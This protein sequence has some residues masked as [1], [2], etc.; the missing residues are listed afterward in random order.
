MSLP[1][2]RS[3]GNLTADRRYDYAAALLKDGDAAAA[4]ELLEQALE[5]EPAWTVGWF[6]LGGARLEAG[7]QSGAIAALREV[8][9]LDPHDSLGAGLHLARLGAAGTPRETA[10]AYVRDLF[11]DY[12]SRFDQALVVGLGYQAP[13]LIAAALRT[14][15]GTRTFDRCL[16]L[17][18][19]TG[20]MAAELDGVGAID[21]V[22]LSAGM[23]DQARA[24]GL[25]R[26]L[27]V[28]EAHDAMRVRDAA[29]YDLV[30]AADVFCYFGDLAP[31][32][33]EVA[34]LLMPDGIFAF[35]VESTPDPAVSVDFHL[36]D[37]LRFRHGQGYVL[38]S[39]AQAG[40]EV[41]RCDPA[42]LRLDRGLPVQGLI[43]VAHKRH[44]GTI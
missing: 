3:S 5:L 40:L 42:T 38:R 7:D 31:A 28:A 26:S 23:I 43:V 18:C 37:S 39:V 36:A 15:V 2:F 13:G 41:A 34:R 44:D 12:A 8:T 10:T 20:L 14:T 16:D 25:Y 24:K 27:E 33:S 1:H 9:R 29:S 32:F 19:G 4:A 11:D 30:T 17:G 22:D 21:G 35:S 6:T